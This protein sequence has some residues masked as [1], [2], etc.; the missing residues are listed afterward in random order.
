[1]LRFDLVTEV[2]V[3]NSKVNHFYLA[4]AMNITPDL[5]SVL[6]ALP[7]AEKLC[8][9]QFLVSELAKEEG[10]T[11]L[12]EGGTY[13]IWSPYDSHEAVHQLEQMLQEYKKT[14]DA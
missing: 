11:P 1:M 5:L 14:E 12:L 7:R 2:F 3:F 13:Q 6:R 9:V 10:V 8:L 4:A